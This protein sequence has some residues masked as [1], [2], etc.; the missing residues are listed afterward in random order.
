MNTLE[1]EFPD[2]NIL[3]IDNTHLSAQDVAKIIV[4]YFHLPYIN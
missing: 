3:T 2:K 4:G 1:G